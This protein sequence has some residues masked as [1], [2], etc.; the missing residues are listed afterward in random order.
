MYAAGCIACLLLLSSVAARADEPKPKA[1]PQL[2]TE[3]QFRRMAIM[4]LE[5]PTGER[6]KEL[7]RFI[8]LYGIESPDVA[9][10]LGSEEMSWIGKDDARSLPL[11]AA[12]MAGNSLSQLH[13][14]N[15][16]NDRYSGLLF[17]FRVYRT[18]Q[19]DDAKFRLEPVE[20][21]LKLHKDDK[22]VAHLQELESKKPT[23]L[24]PEDIEALR[25][26]RGE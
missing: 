8:L 12:Y 23:K 14:G 21:L 5:E 6:G 20:E 1:R 17:L 10:F 22:L 7:S 18:L 3:A 9:V 2:P 26:L 24:S 13:S 25:K 11:F 19:K 15:K 16:R 4:L